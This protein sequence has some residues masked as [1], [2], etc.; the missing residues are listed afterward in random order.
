MS[1]DYEIFPGKKLGDLFKDI[2]TNQVNKKYK[3][4]DYIDEIRQSV[5]H[6]GDYAV[7]GDV[8]KDLL[9]SSVKNDEHLLKLAQ[10]VQRIIAAE[11]KGDADDGILTDAEKKQ[12]MDALEEAQKGIEEPEIPET[13]GSNSDT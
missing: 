13:S 8:I 9:E 4:S 10:I 11:R 1:T 7:L 6:A 3:I 12:L 5:R 2:Y